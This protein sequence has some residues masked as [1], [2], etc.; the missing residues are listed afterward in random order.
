ME[1]EELTSE[2]GDG[3]LFSLIDLSSEVPFAEGEVERNETP[4]RL[5]R[6]LRT[7]LSDYLGDDE[8]LLHLALSS[9]L[10]EHRIYHQR[11]TPWIVEEI[12]RIEML[13]EWPPLDIIF[14]EPLQV[15]N[16]VAW[17]RNPTSTRPQAIPLKG[18]MTT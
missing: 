2:F 12:D 4:S 9:T 7:R 17:F 14:K 3:K 15:T 5:N 6:N 1:I 11:I 16:S 10:H 8:L 13:L 18:P